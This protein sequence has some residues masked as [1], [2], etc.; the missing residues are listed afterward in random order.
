MIL[1]SIH[2]YFSYETDDSWL[3][4]SDARDLRARQRHPE[5]HE[6]VVDINPGIERLPKGD[7]LRAEEVVVGLA[8]QVSF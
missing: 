2:A 8:I 5:H 7:T 4:G 6:L 1:G 3:V